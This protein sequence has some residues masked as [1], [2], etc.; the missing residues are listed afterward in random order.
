MKKILIVFLLLPFYS[1]A[2]DKAKFATQANDTL[3][4][5]RPDLIHF[6][7]IGDK[8]YQINMELKEMPNPVHL[9]H[10]D[11][12]YLSGGYKVGSAEI[13]GVLIND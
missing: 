4:I 9:Q 13:K 5:Q 11:I 3:V 1:Q 8:V 10:I 2:Q 12:P 6:I 7:K